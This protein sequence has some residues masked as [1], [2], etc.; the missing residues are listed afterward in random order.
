MNL[1][2]G[3]RL[4]M[5]IECRVCG[6]KAGTEE[7]ENSGCPRGM[8]A[9]LLKAERLWDCP[10]CH[11]QR[12]LR[13]NVDD[14]IECGKCQIRFSRGI[15]AGEDPATLR[16]ARILDM[17]RNEAIPV[18]VLTEKG[19]GEFQTDKIIRSLERDESRILGGN[20]G[21]ALAAKLKGMGWKG[22]SKG[23]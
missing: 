15:C 23:A 13:I 18:Y 8:I 21:A 19:R 12:Q 5:F 2:M 9:R 14:L 22:P 4:E 1:S 6:G 20:K 7:H 3:Q 17:D 16:Q 10:S 11:A